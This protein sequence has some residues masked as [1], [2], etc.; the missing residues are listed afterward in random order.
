[1]R[2]ERGYCGAETHREEDARCCIVLLP[3]VARLQEVSKKEHRSVKD[4]ESS[5]AEILCWTAIVPRQ[6]GQ[7]QLIRSAPF[8]RLEGTTGI[9]PENLWQRGN[10]RAR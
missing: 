9:M 5:A 2:V 7:V 3:V 4:K 8:G 6:R 10:N 1:M